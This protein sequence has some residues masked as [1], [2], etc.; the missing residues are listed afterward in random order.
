MVAGGAEEF[1]GGRDEGRYLTV[2]L[3]F[4]LVL[5]DGEQKK[6]LRQKKHLALTILH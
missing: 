1:C 6:A 3:L 5:E 2:S 4:F